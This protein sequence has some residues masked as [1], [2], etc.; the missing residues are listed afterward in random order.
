ME[1]GDL[2]ISK[3]VVGYFQG[4]K[5]APSKTVP[6]VLKDKT[7]PS[8]EVPLDILYRQ[9]AAAKTEIEKENFK[10]QIDD[11]IEKRGHLETIVNKIVTRVSVSREHQQ[12][13]T[14]ARPQQLTN[15]DC[16]HQLIKAFS[17]HCFDFGTNTYAL[18]YAYILGNICEDGS[19]SVDN[20]VRTMRQVCKAVTIKDR[21]D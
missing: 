14:L 19:L 6:K 10:S 8:W 4:P 5:Q 18:K 21:I 16:H 11:M 13:L 15:L 9:Q 1:Y 2:S 12:R 7:A 3:L 20:V 17:R